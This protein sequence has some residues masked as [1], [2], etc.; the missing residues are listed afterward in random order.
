[1]TFTIRELLL[2]TVIA[3]LGLGWWLDHSRPAGQPSP[4]MPP[5]LDRFLLTTGGERNDK[6]FLLNPRTGEVWQ[7]AGE[8]SYS[9]SHWEPH[10]STFAE[11]K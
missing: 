6:L 5:A 9:Q 11:K 1:M 7:R 10:T 4:P 8:P 2:T 3:A